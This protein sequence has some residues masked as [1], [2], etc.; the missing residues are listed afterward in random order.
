VAP[1]RTGTE[2]AA[3]FRRAF[4]G[5]LTIDEGVLSTYSKEITMGS[6]KAPAALDKSLKQLREDVKTLKRDLAQIEKRL[7]RLEVREEMIEAPSA[8]G[9]EPVKR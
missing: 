4:R 2:V 8:A 6:E 1:G 7:S 5:P 3:F 9:D